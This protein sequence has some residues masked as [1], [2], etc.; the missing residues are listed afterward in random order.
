M[1]IVRLAVSATGLLAIGFLVLGASAL[2]VRR[3][4]PNVPRLQ[5]GPVSHFAGAQ[6]SYE[7]E[8]YGGVRRLVKFSSQ[9]QH[10]V[11]IVMENRTVDNLFSGYYA[12]PFPGGGTWG[13]A[14]NLYDP[15][16][17]KH[18]LT[19]NSLSAPFDPEHSHDYGFFVEAAGHWDKEKF[20]CPH[21]RCP[22]ESTAYS[23]VPT[24]E[25][26]AY[27]QLVTNWAFASD[28]H[29]AGEGPSWPA[30][31]YLIAGQSG[32][33]TGG[34]TAP[35]SEAENPGGGVNSDLDVSEEG[36]DTE[37][38]PDVVRSG[39]KFCG[40]GSLKTSTI[41]MLEPYAQNEKK[42]PKIEPCEEYGTNGL[43]TILDAAATRFGKPDVLAWQYIAHST[44]S[45]WAAPLGVKHLSEAY[46]SAKNKSA[47]PFAVDGGARQ[48][49]RNLTSS[50]PTRPF[51]HLTYITPC[52]KQSDHPIDSGSSEGPEWL[53]YVVNAIGESRYWPHTAIVVTWDDWGGFFDHVP[54]YHPFPN[55]YPVSGS[56]D[57]NPSDPYE[58]GFR[59][60]LMV[61]SPYAHGR[62]FVSTRTRSFSSILHYVEDQFDL[63]SLDT[64]D[65]YN[66]D[67]QDMFDFSR[68][69]LPYVP[70]TNVPTPK[71]FC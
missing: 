54:A 68:Q 48:F 9:I 29:Q 41:D 19:A 22:P 70:I 21:H 16:D 43:G 42:N 32:G 27:R 37:E 49:V 52:Y 61:I 71:N 53:T 50:S 31:Q 69:P 36:E 4:A 39:N 47:Q 35:F 62:A 8:D 46:E 10:V 40:K 5:R 38:S 1:K 11:V 23:Y 2:A 45:I 34:L 26:D 67:L 56:P 58:Y 6:P 59:V 64:D 20:I 57:G 17:R 13:R 15:N 30:H 33:V 3:T 66:D 28:V 7:I 60:P 12:Q 55:A 18:P 25:T 63:Q 24:M 44:G 65:A 14:L 51:A